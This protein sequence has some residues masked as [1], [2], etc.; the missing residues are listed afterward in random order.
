MPVPVSI[1]RPLPT[2]LNG[3]AVRTRLRPPATLEAGGQRLVVLTNIPTPYRIHFFNRLAAELGRRGIGFGVLFCAQSEANRHWPFDP[4]ELHFS[5]AVLP[6][7]HP[8]IGGITFHLNPT[9]GRWLRQWKPTWLLSAGAWLMPTGLLALAALRSPQ[10]TRL[11]WSEG[12]EDAVL[13][14]TGLVPRLRRQ[15]LRRYDGFAVPNQKSAD[16]LARQLGGTPQCLP[17]PNIVDDSFYVPPTGEQRVATRQKHGIRADDILILQVAQLEERK[18]TM[19]LVQGWTAAAMTCPRLRLVLVGTGTLDRQVREHARDAITAGRLILTGPI[20]AHAV[21]EWLHAV[22][23]FVLNSK[24]DPNPLSA[25]EAGLTG[26]PLLL[27]RR[28]GNFDELHQ[29]GQTG[30][31]IEQVTAE[32]VART[33]RAFAALPTKKRTD[34]AAA[35]R[36]NAAG[37]FSTSAVVTVFVDAVLRVNRTPAFS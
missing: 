36:H 21:R 33:L 23:A 7:L 27:S 2:R 32:A 8:R 12:H 18:G 11:F 25:I 16:Y 24:R 6:G 15:V 29:Q 1:V 3:D 13:H 35:S 9:V 30:I 26:L 20:S 28:I 10:C 5:Y 14:P 22:D 4:S 17:L 19:E 37:R 31:A 34:F